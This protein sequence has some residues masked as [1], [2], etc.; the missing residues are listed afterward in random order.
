M[1]AEQAGKM[2][3]LKGDG[4]YDSCMKIAEMVRNTE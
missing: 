1:A 4:M 2:R 3:N